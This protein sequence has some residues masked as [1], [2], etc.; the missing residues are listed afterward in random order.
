VKKEL[1]F[2]FPRLGSL[3]SYYDMFVYFVRLRR[4]HL[5][6]NVMV[7]TEYLVEIDASHTYRS[8]YP[9]FQTSTLMMNITL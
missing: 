4:T 3:D 7:Y 2:H 1:E 9:K 5:S 6:N 8:K